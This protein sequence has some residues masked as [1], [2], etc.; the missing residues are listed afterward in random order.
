MKQNLPKEKKKSVTSNRT[1]HRVIKMEDHFIVLDCQKGEIWKPF[2]KAWVAQKFIDEVLNTKGM[3]AIAHMSDYENHKGYRALVEA[4]S[5]FDGKAH[6]GS[7][8]DCTAW[9]RKMY[10][11]KPIKK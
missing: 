3:V 2:D 11:R 4:K 5:E 6:H 9:A 7:A 10:E 8:I 1:R